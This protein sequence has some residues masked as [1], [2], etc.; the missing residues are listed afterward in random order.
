M[1][2]KWVIGVPPKSQECCHKALQAEEKAPIRGILLALRYL[3]REAEDAGFKELAK[4]LKEA[5]RECDQHAGT[6]QRLA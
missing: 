1:A 2:T 5:E 3:S 4:A 6:A